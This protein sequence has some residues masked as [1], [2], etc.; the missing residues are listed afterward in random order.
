MSTSSKAQPAAEP[1]QQ[2]KGVTGSEEGAS[3]YG[4]G[5]GGGNTPK[6]GED[7][8]PGGKGKKDKG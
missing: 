5:S 6:P 2:G 1:L 7:H 3:K 8:G 4:S